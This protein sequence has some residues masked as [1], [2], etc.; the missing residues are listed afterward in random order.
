MSGKQI[1]SRFGGDLRDRLG[2]KNT[3]AEAVPGYGVVH[4]SGSVLGEHTVG[5][6]GGLPGLYYA[7][8]PVAI[9]VNKRGSSA[10]WGTPQAVL[11]D[12]ED[13]FEVGDAV[14]PL[15]GEWFMGKSGEGFRI[16]S[17]PN[18]DDIAVVERVGGG[19]SSEGVVM[20]TPTDVLPGI[21]FACDAVEALVTHAPCGSGTVAGD[22]ISVF[23]IN[24]A[25]MG[26][27]PELLFNGVV[28][29]VSKM[30]YAPTYGTSSDCNFVVISASCTEEV[31]LI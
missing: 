6:P 25:F 12:P 14:G 31:E 15:D 7:N 27:P 28:L 4:L 16:F 17:P 19:G 2:W 10:M 11:V 21:G 13:T 30:A 5:K 24:R 18:A 20:C 9:A 22:T 26:M 29:Y 23:D 3:G 8:G 1:L